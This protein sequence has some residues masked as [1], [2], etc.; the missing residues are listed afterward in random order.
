MKYYYYNISIDLLSVGLMFLILFT[1]FSV[2]T[3]LIAINFRFRNNRSKSLVKNWM[4]PFLYRVPNHVEHANKY[5]DF[6]EYES[7]KK[8]I[9]RVE[10]IE[11]MKKNINKRGGFFNQIGH[12]AYLNQNRSGGQDTVDRVSRYVAQT[13]DNSFLPS[14]AGSRLNPNLWRGFNKKAAEI[15]KQS[16]SMREEPGASGLDYTNANGEGMSRNRFEG[17]KRKKRE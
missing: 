2:L 11:E 7:F 16:Y 6:I 17:M 15:S 4:R 5:V 1:M 13:K 3:L 10:E 8:L 12:L 9:F 14:N